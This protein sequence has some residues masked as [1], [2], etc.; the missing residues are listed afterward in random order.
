MGRRTNPAKSPFLKFQSVFLS[1][2]MG[3]LL[4]VLHFVSWTHREQVRKGLPLYPQ[5]HQRTPSTQGRCDKW[6]GAVLFLHPRRE[7]YCLAGLHSWREAD[8]IHILKK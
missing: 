4:P 3:Q 7:N 8:V 1:R 5:Q 2:E 6:G